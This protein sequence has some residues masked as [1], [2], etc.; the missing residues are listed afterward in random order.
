MDENLI[1]ESLSP[2]ERIL[3]PKLEN[4]WKELKELAKDAATD[5]TSA[6][7][8]IGFLICCSVVLL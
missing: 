3:L 6:F 8:G 1:I 4:N 2:I 7:R 5:Q